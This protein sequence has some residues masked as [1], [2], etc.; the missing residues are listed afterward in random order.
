MAPDRTG[1]ES[2]FNHAIITLW[3][4][5]I[6]IP[7]VCSLGFNKYFSCTQENFPSL[8]IKFKQIVLNP[9]QILDVLRAHPLTDPSAHLNWF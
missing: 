9:I 7:Y 4:V 6:S 3:L 5:A 1:K 8:Q 2:F